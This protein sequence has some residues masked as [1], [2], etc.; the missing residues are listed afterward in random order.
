MKFKLF[1]ALPILLVALAGCNRDLSPLNTAT[2]SFAPP[3]PT[4]PCAV[5]PDPGMWQNFE[6]NPNTGPS[7]TWTFGE[8]GA[9]T[10]SWA[11]GFS[12][13]GCGSWKIFTGSASSWGHGFGLTFYNSPAVTAGLTHFQVS[14]QSTATIAAHLYLDEGTL[15]G[16]Q[17]QEWKLP[18]TF[19]ASSTWQT[20]QLPLISFTSPTTGDGMVN[21]QDIIQLWIWQD[22]VPYGGHTIYLDDIKFY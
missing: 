5:P 1:Y 21:T 15:N 22:A 12:A 3:P 2:T 13:T 19:N 18:V 9:I 4:N 11:S 20:L 14:Y 16:G 6:T 8:T 10:P 17:G 7:Y